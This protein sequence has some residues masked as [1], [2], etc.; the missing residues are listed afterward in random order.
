[1][2]ME[3]SFLNMNRGNR[4]SAYMGLELASGV[5][6]KFEKGYNFLD[7][8]VLALQKDDG[9]TVEKGLRNQHLFVVP[10]CTM[11]LRGDYKVLVEPNPALS[12]YGSVQG[13]Y[14]VQPESGRRVPGFWI[15]LRKDL[16]LSNIS[17][18]IR[19]YLRI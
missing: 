6:P 19:M 15:T 7:I 9:T 13:M 12:E 14:Y 16:D 11:D 18:A 1:M 5:E 3:T 8:P 4:L 10:A 2:S 17:Y